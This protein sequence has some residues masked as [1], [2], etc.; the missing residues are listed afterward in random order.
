MPTHNM[1]FLTLGRLSGAEY[2]VQSERF[3]L[4]FDFEFPDLSGKP[5][6]YQASTTLIRPVTVICLKELKLTTNTRNPRPH[7]EAD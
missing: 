4:T 2:F 3:E 6:N 5:E 1:K 7:L